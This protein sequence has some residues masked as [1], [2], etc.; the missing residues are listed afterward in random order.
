MVSSLCGQKNIILF[1]SYIPYY[2]CYITYIISYYID[3]IILYRLYI[4][5][6]SNIITTVILRDIFRTLLN[7]SAVNYFAQ[8]KSMLYVNKTVNMSLILKSL[9][10][11]DQIRGKLQIWSNI[12]KRSL[13]ETSF[14]VQYK[15][16]ITGMLN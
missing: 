14:F 2:M 1:I 10:Q 4:I 3:Y 12:L 9:L 8:K 15:K 6:T 11:C 5:P 16:M 7:I 13:I